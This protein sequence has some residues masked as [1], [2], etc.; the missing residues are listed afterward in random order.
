MEPAEITFFTV[1]ALGIIWNMISSHKEKERP[2]RLAIIEDSD[3]DY[4]M[5]KMFCD[6]DNTV[7]D[8]YT[9]ADNLLWKFTFKRPDAVIADFYL[10]GNI[11]GDQ[12]LKLCDKLRI[13][14]LLVTGNQSPIEGVSKSRQILKSADRKYFD[15]LTSWYKQQLV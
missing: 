12:V 3:D 15:T 7:L 11:K 5:L 1:L 4:A 8:R 9:T 6:F 10:E 14:S 13:P 2:K